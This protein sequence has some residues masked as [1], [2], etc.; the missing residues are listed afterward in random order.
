VCGVAVAPD[1][2][3]MIL[4][5]R[6]QLCLVSFARSIHPLSFSCRFAADW[7][8]NIS[9]AC[10]VYLSYTSKIHMDSRPQ[11]LVYYFRSDSTFCRRA[12]KLVAWLFY[13]P[14]SRGFDSR[15]LRA[16]LNPGI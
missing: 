8:I 10:N 16:A 2:G 7:N 1:T 15:I 13:K 9:H 3:L 11:F 14:E 6:R 5:Y 12:S 4:S